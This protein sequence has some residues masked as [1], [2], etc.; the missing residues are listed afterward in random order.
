MINSSFFY[1]IIN[2]KYVTIGKIINTFGIK[3]EL[4]VESHTD[5]I[6]ER[7]KKNSLI[8]IGDTYK[9]FHV[10]SYRIHKGFIILSLE[11]YNDINL[12]LEL[13][14]KYIYKATEDIKPLGNN[15]FYIRDLINLDVYLQ[16][17]YLGK[18]IAIEKGRAYNFLRI[19][20]EDNKEILI[21]NIYVFVSDVDLVNSRIN[22]TSRSFALL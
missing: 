16:D 20:K 22:L 13:K 3:G 11:E 2:M 5:F 9:K 18:C 12:V 15:E 6:K 8:F 21:P 14:N 17:V 1:T 4:K 7:Y 10:A 19:K